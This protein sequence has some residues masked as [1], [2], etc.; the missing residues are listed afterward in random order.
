MQLGL[1][2]HADLTHDEFKQQFFGFDYEAFQARQASKDLTAGKPYHYANVDKSKLPDSIDWRKK[3]AVSHVK[4]QQRCGSCWA[5]STTGAIEGINAVYTGKLEVL[6]EQ[7][8]I[9]CDIKHDHGCHGGLMDTAFEFVIR[10]G[11][12]DTEK[13]YKYHA[14]EGRCSINRE[15]RH[16]VTID[17]YDDGAQCSL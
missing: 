9:D 1:T 7:E 5:F 10:N 12:I 14:I 6:S 2:E 13:D 4:N 11:G 3:D 15:N 16:V 8:L 17:D